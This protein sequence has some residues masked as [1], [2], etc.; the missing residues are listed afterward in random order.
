MSTLASTEYCPHCKQRVLLVR[1]NFDICLALILLIF[2]AGIGLIIYLII[3][4]SQPKNRCIHCG[5]EINLLP[6]EFSS[7]S[8]LQGSQQALIKNH[9]RDV[10][11][12]EQKIAYCPFCGIKLDKREQKFCENCGSSL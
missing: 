12:E 9:Q 11:N 5:T 1:K 3:Y 8:S 4:Y 10:I 2:T 7:E 6:S